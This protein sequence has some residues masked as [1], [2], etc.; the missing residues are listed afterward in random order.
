MD[1]AASW[2]SLEKLGASRPMD[3]P[4]RQAMRRETELFVET[5]VR[6]DRSVLEFIDADYTFVNERLAKHYDLPGVHGAEMRPVKVDRKTR[7]GLLGHASIFTLVSDG[8]STS[9]VKRGK[10]VL[11]TLL[12]RPP[13]DRQPA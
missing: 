10:W 13:S 2:L 6:E 3:K 11:E 1:F 9:P 7:G 12:A 5:I 4:L 8:D